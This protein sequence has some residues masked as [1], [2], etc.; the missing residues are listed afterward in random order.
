MINNLMGC[1]EKRGKSLNLSKTAAG[2]PR[3]SRNFDM[4]VGPEEKQFLQIE[5][6]NQAL[7]T[8]D[9]SLRICV[10]NKST[11]FGLLIAAALS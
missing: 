10:L 11:F 5:R 8:S 3:R 4:L 2:V 6:L 9:L 7:L 1:I